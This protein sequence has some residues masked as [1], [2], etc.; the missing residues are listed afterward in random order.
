[1][2][3]S[4]KQIISAGGSH[5][6]V[7]RRGHFSCHRG[8]WLGAYVLSPCRVS[9]RNLAAD[10]LSSGFSFVPLRSNST[11]CN[12]FVGLAAPSKRSVPQR[13]IAVAA[14]SCASGSATNLSIS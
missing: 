4:I 3:Q 8:Q 10:V 2:V 14:A 12:Y 1:L 6:P 11:F 7:D 5:G 9:V 13:R